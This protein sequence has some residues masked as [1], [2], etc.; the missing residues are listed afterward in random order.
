MRIM[1]NRCLFIFLLA[2]IVIVPVSAQ[3]D[4]T[5]TEQNASSVIFPQMK[6]TPSDTL[7]HSGIEQQGQQKQLSALTEPLDVKIQSSDSVDI[8][9]QKLIGGNSGEI[10]LI[11]NRLPMGGS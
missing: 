7:K 5:L 10:F 4:D 9:W 2:A 6:I 11:F 3:I 8:E 1:D